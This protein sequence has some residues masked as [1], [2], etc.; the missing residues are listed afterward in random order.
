MRTPI[1][2]SGHFWLQSSSLRKTQNQN[3]LS[4]NS[5]T[6]N[7]SALKV[8]PD[9]N[10]VLFDTEKP[11]GSADFSLGIVALPHQ[12]KQRQHIQ[13]TQ[14]GHDST[15]QWSPTDSGLTF[16]SERK[17]GEARTRRR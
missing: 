16:L 17:T 10:S 5:S 2:S 13:L 12:W 3:S 6:R 11:I 15:P 7:F 14:S 9:G 1:L 8:S 4:M